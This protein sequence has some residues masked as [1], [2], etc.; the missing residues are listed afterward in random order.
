MGYRRETVS[1][2]DDNH[3]EIKARFEYWG[4]STQDVHTIKRFADL[5]VARDNLTAVIEIKDWKKPK[6]KRQLTEGEQE[7]KDGWKGYYFV[8]EKISDVDYIHKL[9]FGECVK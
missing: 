5:L 4:W 3:N 1:K 2:K 8:V 9:F 7:F 6:S